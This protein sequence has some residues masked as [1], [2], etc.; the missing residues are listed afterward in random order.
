MERFYAS[1]EAVRRGEEPPEDGYRGEYIAELATLPG[2]PVPRCSS[3][4]RRRSSAS[5]STSTRGT[6]ETD[7]EAEI[8]EAVALLD[9]FEEDGALWARTSA[10]GDD[11]DRVLVRSDGE[12]TYF[13]TDAA[14][15]RRKYARGFD[16]LIYVLGAD[17]HGY[18]ARLQALAEML[19]HPRESLEVLVY[20][21]VHLVE[22]GAAKKMSKRRGDVVFLDE[23]LD[24]IGVDAARWYLVSRGHDQTIELD[25]D[26]AK[27]RTNK[28]PVYYVQYAHA[29]I[30]GILRNAEE[31]TA[32]PGASTSGARSREERELVKRLLE[33]PAVVARRPSG[34]RHT[35][36]RS[37]RSGSP[38]TSTASTTSTA[39]S[40]PEQEAFRLELVRAVQIVIARCLDLVGRGRAGA[41]V[42]SGD[43]SEVP[44]RNLALELVRVTES[45]ATFASRWIGRGDKNAAD[46]AAVDAMRLML[47]TVSMRGVVVIGEG[48]KDEAPMLFNGEEVG[49]GVGPEVDV[50]VDPLEGTRLT[51]LGMPNAIS[52]IAV[53]ERGTMFFPGA[54]LYMDKIAV[55]PE[56]AD[57]IDIDATPTENL[58]RVAEAK[59][60]RVNDLTVVV[61]E[62]DR[63]DDL[64]AELREAGARVNLIRDGDVAPAIAAAQAGTGVDLLMGIGGTPEGVIS[65]AAIK[66]LG[67]AMQGSSGRGTTTSG[68][69]LVDAGYD[70]DRVLTADDL[71]Q[72]DDVFVAATG[73]TS[74]ALL[75]GVRVVGD[76]VETESI[77]M[78]SRSG[79]FRRIVAS[80]PLTKIQSLMK[81]AR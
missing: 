28:N 64:I 11:K 80:H 7:V 55:G 62:R 48:E 49:D 5:A 36:S 45:A 6:R 19:G 65:A 8:P 46:Q 58:E 70:I 57:A 61:L 30:A 78:R 63:H 14:Y 4:S 26:L 1:V 76:R 2:D 16:R 81:G 66:C 13:A 20:Q 23:L 79:T 67:G 29:R 74:G 43:V 77:V 12:P 53:S 21:L 18:V 73:V 42:G 68:S 60:V 47:D 52:V 40:S 39:C 24:A 22:G 3:G 54:A 25:V 41:D 17:H 69:A 10:H 34:V 37:T 51:A 27:E 56:A 75:R 50:A 31:S 59:R 35:R 15:I 33:F 38:T 32:C 71:V 44:D 72:G 9:T